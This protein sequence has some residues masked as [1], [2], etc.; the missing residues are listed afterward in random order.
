M[1]KKSRKSPF[2]SMI[3]NEKGFLSGSQGKRVSL[4]DAEQGHNKVIVLYLEKG[5]MVQ[6]YGKHYRMW[7][8]A[9]WWSSLLSRLPKI[10]CTC[11]CTLKLMKLL[12][13]TCTSN[14]VEY[15]LCSFHFFVFVCMNTQTCYQ[16]DVKK[17]W[18]APSTCAY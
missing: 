8:P 12:V 18:A 3:T 1:H 6:Y 14:A 13:I 9:E 16:Y 4:V 17:Y 7:L 2:Q 10:S 11:S 5:A 15:F